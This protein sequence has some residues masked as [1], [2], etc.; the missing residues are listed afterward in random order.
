[1]T[2]MRPV[3]ALLTFAAALALAA[4]GGGSSGGGSSATTSA[5]ASVSSVSSTS[6]GGSATKFCAT[7]ED[8]SQRFGSD[9][10][11]PTKSQ[12]D[13]VRKFAGDLEASAPPEMKLAAHGLATYFRAVAD[14]VDKH[15]SNPSPN[16]STLAAFAA[17]IAEI[18]TWAQTNCS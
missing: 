15:G 9:N 1:M 13:Q 5:N 3:L 4:C 14:G 17:S 7:F 8:A 10:T 12:T 18:N 6:V 16:P 11:F 2:R